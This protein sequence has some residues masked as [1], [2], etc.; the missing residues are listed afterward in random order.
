MRCLLLETEDPTS[1][2]K[3]TFSFIRFLRLNMPLDSLY[4]PYRKRY[5]NVLTF[6]IGF[7][8]MAMSGVERSGVM[9]L[10]LY[11]RIVTIQNI[12]LDNKH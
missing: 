7:L 11:F 5:I 12:Y 9:E 3:P 8:P 1:F 4:R 2:L 6:E 10:S